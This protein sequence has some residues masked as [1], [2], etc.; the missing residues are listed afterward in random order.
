MTAYFTLAAVVIRQNEWVQDNR[1]RICPASVVLMLCDLLT[2][3][4]LQATLPKTGKVRPLNLDDIKTSSMLKIAM[5]VSE[6]QTNAVR[7]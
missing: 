6:E 1:P 3:M 2:Q 4:M 5:S 7:F